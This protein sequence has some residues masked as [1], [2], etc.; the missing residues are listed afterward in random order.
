MTQTSLQ[1][2][3]KL[4]GSTSACLVRYLRFLDTSH[5]RFL[6]N[7]GHI[8]LTSLIGLLPNIIGPYGEDHGACGRCAFM[9]L[10]FVHRWRFAYELRPLGEI[11][12]SMH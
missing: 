8:T 10:Y 9:F 5:M 3:T 7:S 1:R 2:E 12:S 11:V 4:A 6:D